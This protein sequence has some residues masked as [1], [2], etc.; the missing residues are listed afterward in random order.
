[1]SGFT[2][3][4]LSP[5]MCSRLLRHESRPGRFYL[6]GERALA[7]L[8]AGYRALLA[9]ALHWRL[10]VVGIGLALLAGAVVLFQQL[11]RELAPQEDQGLII[12]FGVAPEGSTVDYTDK[13][14]RQMEALLGSIPEVQRQFQIVG[15]PSITRA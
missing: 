13:Y 3:L 12:G 14:A 9:R 7:R 8:D 15:F 11:P 4:T 2:A 1:V 6:F 10:P 5:M